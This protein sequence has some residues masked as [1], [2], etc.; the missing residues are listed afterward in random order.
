M[1]GSDHTQE[2]K[3]NWKQKRKKQQKIV[4]VLTRIK[5]SE[6]YGKTKWVFPYISR[7]YSS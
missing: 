6:L 1:P 4:L 5:R 3:E 2:P 7:K